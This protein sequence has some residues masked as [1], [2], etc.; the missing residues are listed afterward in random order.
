MLSRNYIDNLCTGRMETTSIRTLSS[1]SVRNVK[2]CITIFSYH[3][4]YT[5]IY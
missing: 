1:H 4:F 2:T 3:Y 5:N